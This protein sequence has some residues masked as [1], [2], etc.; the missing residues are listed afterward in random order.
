MYAGVGIL[1]MII[2]A[3]QVFS[4]H[5]APRIISGSGVDRKHLAC[6]DDIWYDFFS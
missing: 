1:Y 3:S 2:F 5:S 6:E 4:V